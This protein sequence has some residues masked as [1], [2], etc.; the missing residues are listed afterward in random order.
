[1]TGNANRTPW[2]QCRPTEFHAS[3]QF[4]TTRPPLTRKPRLLVLASTYPRWRDDHEPGFV[5]ELAKRQV[6]RFDVTVLTSSAPGTAKHEHNDGVEVIRYRYAP[7]PLETLVYGGGIS[8][9]LRRTRWKWALVPSFVAAQYAAARRLIRQR[10]FDVVHAHWL[11]PQG[12]V[13][14]SL[15][16]RGNNRPVPFVVTSHG[17]DLFGFGGGLMNA[18]KRQVAASAT[19]MTV[20]STAMRDEAARLG[21]RSERM[22][23]LPMGVDLNERFTPDPLAVRSTDELLFVGRLVPKKGLCY[24]LDA[25]PAVIAQHPTAYLS[26]AGFGPEETSLRAQAQALAIE[27]HVRFVGAV[28]QASLPEL[29]RRAA[30]LVAPYVRDPTGDQEGLPVVLMEAIACDCPAVVGD[31]AGIDDLLGPEASDLRVQPTDRAAL[32]AAVSAL[33]ADP[34]AARQRALSLREKLVDKIDWDCVAKA[35]GD[36]LAAAIG[37]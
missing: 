8:T 24:L 18:V 11:I 7:R 6:D 32:A 23:V 36:V 25:L 31:V 10:R 5:H 27:E 14:Q 37:A 35:Y 9:H 12:L 21:M 13:A 33:L 3:D 22:V 30:G 15:S 17:G 2:R 34:E 19:A 20:V 4:E 1:L 26:V 16:G 29:Y 28:P